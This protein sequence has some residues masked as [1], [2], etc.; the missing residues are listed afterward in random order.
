MW[1]TVH[2]TKDLYRFQ[3]FLF[4]LLLSILNQ[5]VTW[6]YLISAPGTTFQL[7]CLSLWCSPWVC[8]GARISHFFSPADDMVLTSFSNP[9]IISLSGAKRL[10]ICKYFLVRRIFHLFYPS[11]FHVC[12]KLYQYFKFCF[13]QLPLALKDRDATLAQVRL[14]EN[15]FGKGSVSGINTSILF[16]QTT[17]ELHLRNKGIFWGSADDSWDLIF[18]NDTFVY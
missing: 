11:E 10:L 17:Q 8:H 6:N 2:H 15:P 18:S 4:L 16:K 7:C 14:S 12:W 13:P 3:S 1:M 9:F 5:H